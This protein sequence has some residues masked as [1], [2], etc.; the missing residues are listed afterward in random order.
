M[1][2][3]I[4]SII[5]FILALLPFFKTM[6]ATIFIGV[7]TI[8]LASIYEK[9][10]Q[11]DIKEKKKKDIP[12]IAVII[13]IM[14]MVISVVNFGLS[15]ENDQ[16]PIDLLQTRVNSFESFSMADEIT[17]DNMI[18]ILVKDVNNDGNKYLITLEITGLAENIKVSLN[19]FFIYNEVNKEIVF[20][21]DS[22]MDNI[23]FY[24]NVQKNEIKEDTLIFELDNVENTEELFLVYKNN[25]N[26]VKIKL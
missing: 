12:I 13:S 23:T 4:L 18:K 7:C 17:V 14:A 3:L 16:E 11:Q 22:V 6:I 24:S 5:C 8:I 1:S 19:D 21:K 10:Q 26:S 25:V 20:A 2:I 15:V 9:K